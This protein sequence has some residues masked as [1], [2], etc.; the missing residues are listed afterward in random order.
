MG[1]KIYVGNLGE[2]TRGPELQKLFAVHGTVKWADVATDP[3]SGASRGFGFVMMGSEQEA[4]R[5]VAALN[6]AGHE[7]R[8]L[9][10]GPALPK[11]AAAARTAGKPSRSGRP[12][13]R[14]SRPGRPG[15]GPNPAHRS[16]RR[17]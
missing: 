11:G 16:H 9:K 4:Q 7:G 14:A 3:A 12:G 15:G 10:V 2:A 8:L 17:R 1:C 5:A 13:G 6:G